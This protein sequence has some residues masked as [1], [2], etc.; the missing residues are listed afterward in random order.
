RGLKLLE[1][2]QEKGS[3]YASLLRVEVTTASGARHAA[4][5]TVFRGRPRLVEVD[6][7]GVGLVPQGELLPTRHQ[8]RP[9]VLGR[10]ATLLGGRGINI[11]AL[12]MGAA[13]EVGG[14][15]VHT[16]GEALALYQVSRALSEDELAALRKLPL[17]VAALPL[18]LES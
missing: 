4:A 3:D 8:D 17:I 7:Y 9:G 18:S 11:G 1:T 2:R 12:H 16:L 10:L 14:G 15:A 13:E 6:G 5:G